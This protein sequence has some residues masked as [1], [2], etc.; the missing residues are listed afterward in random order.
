LDS[1]S[2]GSNGMR[3]SAKKKRI[4][5]ASRARVRSDHALVG[6]WEDP[7]EKVRVLVRYNHPLVG[8]WEEVEN[9]VSETSVVYKIAVVDGHFVVSG[10]DESDGTKFKISNVQWDGAG[11]Q[12]TSLFPPT[13]H[14]VKHVL[15]AFKPGL[16]DH[17]ITSTDYEVWRKRPQKKRRQRA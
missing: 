9:P 1:Q 4:A 5:A 8:T 7:E 12:F 6:T 15:R 16:V 3:K 17:E 14:R 13:G 10:I 11:L 2:K